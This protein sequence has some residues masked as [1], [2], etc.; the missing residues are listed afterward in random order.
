MSGCWVVV[1]QIGGTPEYIVDNW[2][3]LVGSAQRLAELR[4]ASA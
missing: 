1:A 3:R 4:A 2:E